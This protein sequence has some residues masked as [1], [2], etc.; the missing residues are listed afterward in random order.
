L[1]VGDHHDV[2]IVPDVNDIRIVS[3]HARE[4]RREILCVRRKFD[5]VRLLALR[6][7]RELVVRRKILSPSIILDEDGRGVRLVAKRLGKQRDYPFRRTAAALELLRF[8]LECVMEG[9]V[10]LRRIRG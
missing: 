6:F 2:A 3:F 1:R 4:Q 7:E 5:E 10:G 8:G 9:T